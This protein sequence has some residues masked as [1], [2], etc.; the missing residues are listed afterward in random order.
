MV[1]TATGSAGTG[2]AGH[3]I[4]QGDHRTGHLARLDGHTLVRVGPRDAHAR[5]ELPVL[6]HG[7]VLR[8]AP[9]GVLPGMLGGAAPAAQEVAVHGDQHVGLGEV[10]GGHH[11]QAE[12]LEVGARDA[13]IADAVHLHMVHLG[14]TGGG[15]T[16]DGGLGAIAGVQL[17]DRGLGA[18]ADHRGRQHHDALASGAQ[19]DQLAA[20]G[21]VGIGPCGGRQTLGTL[22]HR[23]PKALAVVQRQ[24]R[25]VD[26]GVDR[27][28]VQPGVPVDAVARVA[29]DV[30]GAAFARLH[31]DAGVVLTVVV[32]AGV[33]GGHAG[34]DLL[35]LVDVGDALDHRRLAG[36]EAG[37][38]Q[39]EAQELEEIAAARGGSRQA[40]VRQ[41]LIDGQRSLELVV[42]ALDRFAGLVQLGQV[43][44]VTL[45]ARHAARRCS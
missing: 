5:L 29:H 33:P 22:H 10:V 1:Q 40:L 37:G 18:G 11:P 26:P 45:G 13:G 25:A 8:T 27:A 41:H 38:A 15:L 31:Q 34:H 35:G 12:A 4:V 42:P 19:F 21:L 14:T 17:G 6:V 20:D 43:L 3:R 24:Q 36:R 30:D 39:A 28:L 7:P 23:A 2:L 32:G 9:A 16:L 44:P